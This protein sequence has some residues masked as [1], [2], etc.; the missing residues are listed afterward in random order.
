[1]I[2]SGALL[3]PLTLLSN[4]LNSIPIHLFPSAPSHSSKRRRTRSSKSLNTTQLLTLH[5]V[6][7]RDKEDRHASGWK[8]YIDTI[9]Q[10]FDWHPLSWLV[11]G[12]RRIESVPTAARRH[13]ELVKAKFDDDLVV[14]HRVL[15]SPLGLHHYGTDGRAKR[16]PSK[17][18]FLASL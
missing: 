7:T 8:E 6:L 3:N 5:L 10:D 9:P 18:K 14:L 15:V 17:I 11:H 13:A 4:P 2:P 1:M 12:D 16:I